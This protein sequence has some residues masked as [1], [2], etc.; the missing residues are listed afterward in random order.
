MW[1][2]KYYLATGQLRSKT[3]PNL[4]EATDFMVY[5]ISAW[6]VHDCYRVD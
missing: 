1:L 6:D 3:F 5:R 4:A 2:I